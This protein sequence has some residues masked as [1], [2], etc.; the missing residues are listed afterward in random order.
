MTTGDLEA[1]GDP[2]LSAFPLGREPVTPAP[3]EPGVLS[4]PPAVESGVGVAVTVTV[5]R[6]TVTV[7]GEQ[8]P[9]PPAPAAPDD[10]EEAGATVTNLV[11]VDVP[12]KVVVGLPSAPPAPSVS[13]G[14]VE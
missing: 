8:L 10:A 4:A 12:L 14:F 3:E 6:A 7:T 2:A 11:E 13:A 1:L 5:D 9:S